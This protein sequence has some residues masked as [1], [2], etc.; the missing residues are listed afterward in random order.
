MS[1]FEPATL[2]YACQIHKSYDVMTS[3]ITVGFRWSPSQ[4]W[5]CHAIEQFF[6]SQYIQLI[7]PTIY[8]NPRVSPNFSR[9]LML[10][11]LD[12][13]IYFSPNIWFTLLFEIFLPNNIC[14]NHHIILCVTAL[15]QSNSLLVTTIEL[16]N[17]IVNFWS[18]G[19][20]L[21]VG[22]FT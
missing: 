4:Y 19:F 21:S 17:D 14:I 9:R 8:E 11:V 12:L 16:L 18:L 2:K 3:S 22:S 6:H 15:I 20:Q 1:L 7:E 13:L 10:L 5:S